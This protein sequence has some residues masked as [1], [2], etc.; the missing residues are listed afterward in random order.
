MTVNAAN[1]APSS[2]ITSPANNA[3]YTAP[4]TIAISASASDS[5]GT[6]SRVD[7]YQGSTLLGSDTVSPYAFTWTN[8]PAG[9]Y[10]LTARATDNGGAVG[11]SA[12]ITVTVNPPANQ[13]PTAAITSPANNATY[14]APAAIVINANAA[15]SDGTVAR[16]EFY[17]G[18]TLLGTDTSAPY[19]F[20][21]SNVPAGSYSLTARAFD[22]AG[23][24]G[25]S[26]GG[27]RHRQPCAAA[28]DECRVHARV[29][30]RPERRVLPGRSAA[31]RRS[32]Q[33]GAG[34]FPRHRQAARREQR[35]HR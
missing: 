32:P 29:R 7:F 1:Q 11:T 31:R 20:T 10:A 34:R 18:T 23:G 27:E 21:W 22:N 16:V 28:G 30:S 2:A 14:T 13:V 33:R 35:D 4:A 3:T 19:S 25:T 5:N 12:A 15:D 9:T 24:T 8:V 6:V 17:Q 26:S